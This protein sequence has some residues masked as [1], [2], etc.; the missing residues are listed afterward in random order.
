MTGRLRTVMR[1]NALLAAAIATAALAMPRVCASAPAHRRAPPMARA[2]PVSA[3]LTRISLLGTSGGPRAMPARSEPTNLLV[4]DGVPYL[5]DADPGGARQLALAGFEA[6][7]I[8]TIFITHHQIV[9]LVCVGG[10][11]NRTALVTTALI[12]APT[13]RLLPA[14]GPATHAGPL[15]SGRRATRRAGRVG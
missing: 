2:H 3:G 6:P 1:A 5:I 13:C 11:S 15:E 4:V 7:Q 8:R 12:S 9:E 14:G 10:A